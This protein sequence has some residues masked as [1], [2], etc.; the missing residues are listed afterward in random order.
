MEQII[1]TAAP[2]QGRAPTTTTQVDLEQFAAAI[3]TAHAQVRTALSGA[4]QH[5]LTAGST[6]IKAKALLRHGG[7]GPF[8]RRCDLGE[9]QSARYMQLYN[10]WMAN[11][12]RRDEFAGASIEGTIKKFAPAKHHERSARKRQQ[13]QDGRSTTTALD[14]L[15]S[16]D[17][18]SLTER[19]RFLSSVGL[20]RLALALPEGWLRSIERYLREPVSALTPATELVLNST[21]YPAMPSFLQR[22]APFP[23]AAEEPRNIH[24]GDMIVDPDVIQEAQS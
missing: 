13:K 12:S 6:L 4:I 8:L 24:A 17:K 3:K 16:W 10:L 21:E 14:I 9:R 1:D 11:P 15:E 19:T 2:G 23:P 20:K 7:W 22:A 5:A 18:A